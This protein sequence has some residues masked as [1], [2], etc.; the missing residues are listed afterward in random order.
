[1]GRLTLSSDKKSLVADINS[2]VEFELM[3]VAFKATLGSHDLSQAIY[4]ETFTFPLDNLAN[5]C[6]LWATGF[7][8]NKEALSAVMDILMPQAQRRNLFQSTSQRQQEVS[9]E[10]SQSAA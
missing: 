10:P 8:W 1:M 9:R 4:T 2:N 7:N 6:A 3:K 5:V